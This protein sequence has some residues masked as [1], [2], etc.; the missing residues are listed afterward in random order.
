VAAS[1]AMLA[2]PVAAATPPAGPSAQ[3]QGRFG[4]AWIGASWTVADH[5]L[6][7]L[8]IHDKVNHVAIKVSAPFRLVM[9]DGSTYGIKNMQLLGTPRRRTLAADPEA[10][11]LAA[12]FPGRAIE[13]HFGDATGRFDVRWRLVQRKGSHYLREIVTI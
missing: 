6:G 12:H 9:D 5:H 10:A 8:T 1:V 7:A 11:R 3:P 13:A 2:G 4:N